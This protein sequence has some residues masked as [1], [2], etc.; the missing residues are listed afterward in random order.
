VT[1]V[2]PA[3]DAGAVLRRALRIGSDFILPPTCLGCRAR[4]D[5]GSA[6]CVDCWQRL[7][8]IEP[9]LCP[10]TGRPFVYDP[11][12]GVV[13]AAALARPP[14]AGRVR[15]AVRYD[16]V[17]RAMVH[18]LKYRDRAEYCATMAA[19]MARAGGQLLDDADLIVP[20]PL[21]HG[22]LWRRRYNQSAMLAM[23]IAAR[24]GCAV[25]T[26]GLR[27]VRRTRAQ[28]GL[29]T[30]DRRKNV[31]GAFATAGNGKERLDGRRVVLID[32]VITTGA[33]ADAC[34]QALFDGG[35]ESVDVL[36]FALVCEPVSP[37][38]TG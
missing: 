1:A 26:S 9:P 30:S 33:T 8:F 16:N 3:I 14:V 5:A 25:A 13:S 31:R 37:A 11:G 28:V 21:H 34:A 23:A 6:L 24:S 27:R 4:I 38:G 2:R 17:A 20:V 22:R 35:A 29:K 15:A 32:D 36:A 12:A 19:M 18:A 10:R 7:D